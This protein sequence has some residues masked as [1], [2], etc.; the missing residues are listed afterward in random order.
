MSEGATVPTL[1][2]PTLAAAVDPVALRAL[3]HQLLASYLSGRRWFGAKGT[4][5]ARVAVHDAIPLATT[6]RDGAL[7]AAVVRVEVELR[8][9][10]VERYQL[11]LAARPLDAG[12]AAP[13]A[14]LATLEGE[15]GAR[16]VLF[17][18]LEDA[19]VLHLLAVGLESGARYTHDGTSWIIA[20][21][22]GGG[23][24]AEG[25]SR[26]R[27]AL[28]SSEQSNSSVMFGDV[29]ILKLYRRLEAGTNPDVEMTRALSTHGGYA[30]VPALLGTITFEDNDGG[31]T[32]AGMAQRI[33]PGARDGWT[34]A[35]EAAG[36]YLDGSDD[37]AT[38]PFA[39]EM[40]ELG[41][42]TRSLHDALYALANEEGFEPRAGS[43][44]DVEG[45]ATRV[46]D[47]VRD[48]TEVLAR[49]RDGMRLAGPDVAV[50]DAILRRRAELLGD[51]E[52]VAD[53]VGEHPGLL[54]RHHGDYHLGQVLRGADGRF[55]IIDFE[56][57]PARLLAERRA[58]SSPLRDVAGMFRSIA[59]AG[60]TAAMRAGGVGINPTVE[61]R[62]SRWERG[63]RDAFLSGY[64][65]GG[66][67]A[68]LPEPAP[69]VRH[70]I[71]LFE[72]EKV[73]YE[74]RYELDNRPDWVWIPLRGIGKLL[75]SPD[76]PRRGGA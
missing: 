64:M 13:R 70:L 45:W 62:R 59:Y 6:A 43:A 26:T 4:E 66:A 52:S 18:A 29:A 5:P 32:V 7:N 53:A 38:N 21:E 50:A 8:D 60:A 54:I 22:A 42:V 14:V 58:P 71:M 23:A 55:M 10:R 25:L 44:S 72:M 15:D 40:E 76:I 12:E 51:V 49:S 24:V 57:E 35:L 31:V 16:G 17:D 33:V 30:N 63:A 9:G 48:S 61:I 27:G 20:P 47:L 2:V 1:R 37:D 73:F 19:A 41:R 39:I 69:A 11:P 65:E 34:L 46:R 74:L 28:G 56:G 3:P 75:G 68:F 36:A 67:A